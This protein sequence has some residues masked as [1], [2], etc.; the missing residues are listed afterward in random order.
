M[1][2][3]KAED[4]MSE[5]ANEEVTPLLYEEVSDKRLK[6]IVSDM[7]LQCRANG[8]IDYF[9]RVIHTKPPLGTFE[10]YGECYVKPDEREKL[11]AIGRERYVDYQYNICKNLLPIDEMAVKLKLSRSQI[12][13]LLNKIADMTVSG[14]P[15]DQREAAR[16]VR[17]FK[18]VLKNEFKYLMDY[19]TIN[20]IIKWY[21]KYA[22][23]S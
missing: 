23:R 2:T 14:S 18:S 9:R 16:F 13:S 4:C 6:D 12:D 3:T 15:S 22:K 7:R 8:P 21:T 1:C 20:V 17:W 10:H 5:M 11:H 19:L